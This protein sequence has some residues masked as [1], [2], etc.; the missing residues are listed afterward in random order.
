MDRRSGRTSGRNHAGMFRPLAARLQLRS[1]APAGRRRLQAVDGRAFQAKPACVRTSCF[2]SRRQPIISA[3]S[4]PISPGRSESTAACIALSGKTIL[5]KL[6]ILAK[7]QLA[8]ASLSTSRQIIRHRPLSGQ[9]ACRNRLVF[10][11]SA[12]LM[13]EPLWNRNFIDA[14]AITVAGAFWHRDAR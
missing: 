12:N 4:S 1:V 2:L 9:E 6:E 14:C 8:A 5:P 11:F 3:P 10:L 7:A 13:I